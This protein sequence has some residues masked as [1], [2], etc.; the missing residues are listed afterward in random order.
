MAHC[1]AI[2]STGR[3]FLAASVWRRHLGPLLVILAGWKAVWVQP[4]RAADE[5]LTAVPRVISGGKLVI[6]VG[7]TSTPSSLAATTHVT[8]N[9]SA[10]SGMGSQTL[11]WNPEAHL[12][13]AQLVCAATGERI[14]IGRDKSETVYIDWSRDKLE[15]KR[16]GRLT[17]IIGRP[18]QLAPGVYR[19]KLRADLQNPAVEVDG[20]TIEPQVIN[21]PLVVE[22][23]IVVAVAGRRLTKVAFQPPGDNLPLRVGTPPTVALGVLAVGCDLGTGMLTVDWKS[24]EGE[25]RRALRL[26]LPVDG[27]VVPSIK[28][29]D[30]RIE[31]HSDWADLP[32][33]SDVS[34]ITSAGDEALPQTTERKYEVV[35]RTPD[36]FLPGSLQAAITWDQ[37]REAAW[38]EPLQKSVPPQTILPG[39][40]VEPRIVFGG[41]AVMIRG[42]SETQSDSLRVKFS[43]PRGEPRLLLLPWLGAVGR[44]HFF[45]DR[46]LPE[47]LGR[48]QFAREDSADAQE[49]VT[50]EVVLG[51][52]KGLDEV[53]VFASAPP[54]WVNESLGWKITSR[55]A[56]RFWTT[57]DFCRNARLEDGAVLKKSGS[58]E[59]LPLDP[60][61][62]PLVSFDAV[63]EEV[64]AA[65]APAKA[66]S[67]EAPAA[68]DRTWPVGASPQQSPWLLLT[69]DLDR[70]ERQG[71]RRDRTGRYEFEYR[72]VLS[73]EDTLGRPFARVVRYPFVVVVSTDWEYYRWIAVGLVSLFALAVAAITLYRR[74]QGPRLRPQQT[75]V[76]IHDGTE[77]ADLFHRP[78]VVVAQPGSSDLPTSGLPGAQ[79]PAA[80]ATPAKAADRDSGHFDCE[81]SSSS[82][83]DRGI[84]QGPDPWSRD[85]S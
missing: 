34:E 69:V 26:P 41:E 56:F 50:A 51:S 43:G 59:W 40:A 11:T 35:V 3:V 68:S 39:V 79:S 61:R 16:P 18:R 32:I 2:A 37:S 25:E 71:P 24:S 44:W 75:K 58:G 19:G 54:F 31:C 10:W 76:A 27:F 33:W 20:R 15:A 36:W 8:F 21:H 49:A 64:S 46:Y 81:D 66:T 45:G 22:W 84:I 42:C 53:E 17:L 65:G 60:M 57:P 52:E 4:G 48:Y 5:K 7:A 23:E 29:K 78:A 38:A 14:G 85:E 62:D 80:G 30:N 12:A 55:P 63:P 9:E 47:D 13:E 72:M 83:L 77:E 82:M 6:Y 74:A 73:G 1:D 28:S 67:S 70:E